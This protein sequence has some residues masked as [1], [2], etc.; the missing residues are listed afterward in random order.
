MK[1]IFKLYGLLFNIT[2]VIIYIFKKNSIY[3]LLIH[4]NV[5]V[6]YNPRSLC[7]FQYFNFCLENDESIELILHFFFFF[8]KILK[9][10]LISLNFEF[11]PYII[12]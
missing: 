7:N 10:S 5:F 1:C 9:S 12:S 8:D 3:V 2:N 4:S 11:Q 6:K